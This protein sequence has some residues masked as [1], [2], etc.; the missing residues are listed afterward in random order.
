YYSLL[1]R[2]SNPG[3][4]DIPAGYSY[5]KY[6]SGRLTRYRGDFPYPTVLDITAGELPAGQTNMKVDKYVHFIN[7]IYEDEFIVISRKTHSLL[8]YIVTFSYL[9]LINILLLLPM[10]RRRRKEPKA[11]RRNYYRSRINAVLFASLFLTLVVMAALSVTFVYKRNTSNMNSFMSEKIT[12]IQSVLEE[13]CR[14]VTSL[15]SLNNRDL[16]QFLESVGS[17]MKADIT[18]YSTNGKVFVSTTSDVFDKM[19]IGARMNEDAYYNIKYRNL[20]LYIN[21]EQL[22]GEKYYSLY[23]PIINGTGKTIAIA[24]VPYTE[25]NIDFKNE[26]LFAA[27]TFINVFLILIVLTLIISTTVVNNMFKPLV[28]MGKKMHSA[29]LQGL[30]YIIYKR[31]DEVSSLVEAYNRMVHDLYESM[32]QVTQAERDKAW[33]EMARQVAHEI[34]NP[35]TPIKLELQRLIRLKERNDPSWSEKFDR[36]SAIVLEHIDILTDTANEFSTFAKLYTEEPVLMDIDQ[37]LKDQIVIFDNKE[38]I[39]MS[40]IGLSQSYVM[41]PK[42]QL[43]RVFVNLITNAI[44]AVDISQEDARDSGR[45]VVQGRILISLRNSMKDGFYDIVFE[46]NGPGVKEENQAKLFTPNFTTKSAGTG[47]G[48]AICRNIVEKCNGTINYQRSF[49]LSGACFIVTLPKAS[50]TQ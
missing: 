14:D 38:N 19:E 1:G 49:T 36:V 48:L 16:V 18:L 32:K 15:S 35:L 25:Q 4:V 26:A 42:P 34:K 28:E 31:E 11:F 29:D 23:A 37:T 2:N 12:S 50:N 41:A 40:Y 39:T 9:L 3:N 5:A 6:N 10:M 22:R 33:S 43:I 21:P 8:T 7:K 13:E 47:L 17:E 30:S 20:R 45:E 27:A 44:Q 24:C 46:D